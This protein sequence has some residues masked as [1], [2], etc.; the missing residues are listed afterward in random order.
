MGKL[1]FYEIDEKYIDFLSHYSE[2]CVS[3]CKNP[4]ELFQKIYRNPFWNKRNEVFCPAFF[5]Q[6]KTQAALRNDR[7]HKNR[8]YGGA[9]LEQYVPGS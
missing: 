2:H 6:T 7:L 8:R 9:E 3:Q 1:R 5:L 4:T